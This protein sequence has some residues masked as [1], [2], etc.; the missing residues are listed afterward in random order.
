MRQLRIA[1]A[2][3]LTATVRELILVDPDG[4]VLP[5]FAPG[6]HLAI[7]LEAGRR[8]SYSLTGPSVR[9]DH[10]AVSVRR[11]ADGHGG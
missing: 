1:D 7:D 10:Y 9:P 11:E 8:N 2:A 6:S 3:M 4:G 5:S